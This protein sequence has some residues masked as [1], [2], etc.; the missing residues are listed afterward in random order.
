M[1]GFLLEV[2]ERLGLRVGDLAA[3]VGAR[4]LHE[5]HV[6]GDLD[7][8]DVDPEARLR[9]RAHVRLHG[10]RLLLRELEALL[11]HPLLVGEGL[12]VQGHVARGALRANPLDDDLLAQVEIGVV[13]GV[14]V[15][16]HLDAVRAGLDQPTDRPPFEHVRHAVFRIRVVPGF[17]VGEEH[18]GARRLRLERR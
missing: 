8:E 15:D 11:V 10:L 18:A 17:L 13:K 7:L 12:D 9:E 16:Q 4:A 2:A 5:R 14:V 3:L 6:H 1:N